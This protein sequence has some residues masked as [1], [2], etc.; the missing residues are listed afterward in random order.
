VWHWIRV[1]EG[2]DPTGKGGDIM[3]E[4][5]MCSDCLLFQANGDEPEPGQWRRR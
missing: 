1:R 4:R 3:H 5:D 2:G